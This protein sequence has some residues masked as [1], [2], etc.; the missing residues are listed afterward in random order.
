MQ[1]LLLISMHEDWHLLFKGQNASS[2]AVCFPAYMLSGGH[3]FLSN[4]CLLPISLTGHSKIFQKK[5]NSETM[6]IWKFDVHNHGGGHKRFIDVKNSRK[7]SSI[8]LIEEYEIGFWN[9]SQDFIYLY[10][11]WI[12]RR[13]CIYQCMRNG[14]FYSRTKKYQVMLCC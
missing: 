1:T 2:H 9:F 13:C 10:R 4:C 12:C 8:Y 5:P 6:Q 11:L 7:E 3:K 14:N